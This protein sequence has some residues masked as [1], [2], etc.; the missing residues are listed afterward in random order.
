[1]GLIEDKD[2]ASPI[3]SFDCGEAE[4]SIIGSPPTFFEVDVILTGFNTISPLS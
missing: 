1:M 4:I 2:L 3:T